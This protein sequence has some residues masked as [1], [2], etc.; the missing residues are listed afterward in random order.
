[1]ERCILKRFP[2]SFEEH[3]VSPEDG[4]YLSCCSCLIGLG[5]SEVVSLSLPSSLVS[6]SIVVAVV[7]VPNAQSMGNFLPEKYGLTIPHKE[8]T[9]GDTHQEND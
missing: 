5:Y 3:E 4:C 1:L 8:E 6:H 2:S 7:F 9:E